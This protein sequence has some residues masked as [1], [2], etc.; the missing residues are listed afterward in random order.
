MYFNIKNI[1]T[2][3][4]FGDKNNYINIYINLYNALK[5]A[6]LDR[7]LDT[8][9]KLP[10]S[11]VL[12]KDLNISRSTVLKAYELLVLERYVTSIPG[13]GYYISPTKTKKT[14][15]NLT[16]LVEKGK[17]PT[18][19][20]RGNSFRK[21]IQLISKYSEKGI[22]F[23]PG[24]PPLDVFPIQLWKKTT[25][26]YWKTVKS[27]QLSYSNTIGLECLRENVSNYLKIY[28]NINCSSEQIVITTGSLHS[29]SLI[30]DALVDKKNEVVIEN[31]T[32]P[33]AYNL[34]NSLQAKICAAT[35]DTEG[36]VL[37]NLKCKTPKLIYTT[38]S[39]Q[40]P[41]GIKMSLNRR[42]ELLNW[43]AKKNSIVIEDDYDHEF[44]NWRNPI[45]SIFSLD[46]QKRTIYLGTFNKLLHPSIRLGYMIVPH[47]LLDTIKAL[48]EQSSRFVATSSQKILSDF[49][50]KDYL[51]KQ[52]RKVIE[53]SV[54]RKK[55][56]SETFLSC[57]EENIIINHKNTGLQV[58]GN[59]KSNI[60]DVRL[61]EYLKEKG[62]VTH[63]FSNYFIEGKKRS[64]IVMGYS[65]VNTKVIKETIFK[66][67]D[68]YTNFIE[69]R[70]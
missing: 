21:N 68:E 35:I 46:N 1:L 5:K 8:D 70:L 18:I 63:P 34:F 45:S 38:P 42:L 50:E 3:H 9:L 28:R 53:V 54:E 61:S 17:Y 56:F 65:S 29:L 47:Y 59:V 57:F 26:D 27:S 22:A 10:P 55:V 7:T 20:K 40:Y 41:T 12:A 33:H 67:W 49:I 52:L 23:R 39:N 44:S 43:A 60:D 64:G 66:M 4:G 16:T 37:K 51:N 36:I 25:N 48:Y 15:H 19:S 24:L 32:Y 13:S 69:N 58:I 2:S 6:I 31:P 11:R 30:G 14:Q 62:I